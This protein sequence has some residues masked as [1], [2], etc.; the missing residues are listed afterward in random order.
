MHVESDK[1][2]LFYNL[3][4]ELKVEVLN[5][6]NLEQNLAIL[7]GKTTYL[8]THVL[9]LASSHFLANITD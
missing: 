1:V 3:P 5:N 6:K 8:I 9:M 4:V 2:S 7:C